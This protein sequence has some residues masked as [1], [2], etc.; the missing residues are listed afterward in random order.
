MSYQPDV[1]VP[2]NATVWPLIRRWT[3]TGISVVLFLAAAAVLVGAIGDATD[4]EGWILAWLGAIIPIFIVV[5]VF[6]WVDRLESEP[7]RLLLFAFLWGALVSTAGALFLNAIGMSFFAGLQLDPMVTGAVVVAPIVE[8]VLKCAGVLALFLLARREFNGVTDG[9]VYSGLVAAGFA[10]VEN[11]LYLGRA[12]TAAGGPAVFELFVLRCL[13]SPFAHPMFTI[14]FGL[15]LGFVAH[16]RRS[17]AALVLPAIGL[18]A[19]IGLHALWN[20]SAVQTMDTFFVLYV[21]LQVPLF[22]AFLGMIWWARRRETRLMRGYLQGYGLGGW[23]TPVEV[24]MIS[25]P[26][27]RRAARAW[28][29][30]AGGARGEQAMTAFQDEAIALAVARKHIERGDDD[31][32]WRRAEAT[33]LHTLPQHRATFTGGVIAPPPPPQQVRAG[34]AWS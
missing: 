4:T 6:L 16:R 1:S 22:L 10:F 28:A 14:C 8:E 7:A 9:L 18:I 29:R 27:Q 30:R 19:A 21:G 17:R 12:Y 33:L 32:V 11:L 34:G 31:E 3:L 13:L 26:R 24:Q 5:P 2:H 20:L 15:A 25:S 23:F